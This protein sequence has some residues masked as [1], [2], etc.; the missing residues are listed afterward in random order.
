MNRQDCLQAYQEFTGKASENTRQLSFAALAVIWIFK[1]ESAAGHYLFPGLL[2]W[3]GVFAVAALSF[4]FLQYGYGAAAWGCFHRTKERSGVSRQDEFRAPDWM[5]W[6]T[7]AFFIVKVISVIVSYVLLL[8]YLFKV[9][10]R[11]A[12]A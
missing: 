3:A 7:N 2:L 9:V 8:V 5:N 12:A 6:P 10:G 1:P 11:Q 4:D